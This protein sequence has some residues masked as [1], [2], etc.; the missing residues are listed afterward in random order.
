MV[1][2]V[3]GTLLAPRLRPR[4][5]PYLFRYD[6]SLCPCLG[7][8]SESRRRA[9][10]RQSLLAEAEDELGVVGHLL[11]RPGRIPRELRVDFLYALQGAD[12]LPDLLLDERADGAAHGGEREGH[13]DFRP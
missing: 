4:S 13:V 5:P 8:T 11:W 1:C 9:T 2:A 12:R 3:G 6:G 10:F 7:T